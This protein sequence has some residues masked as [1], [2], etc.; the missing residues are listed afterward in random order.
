[1]SSVRQRGVP[2]TISPG[3][4]EVRVDDEHEIGEL[5]ERVAA[6]SSNEEMRVALFRRRFGL[7]RFHL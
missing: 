5:L 1:L 7:A 4:A 2:D 6:R 3:T